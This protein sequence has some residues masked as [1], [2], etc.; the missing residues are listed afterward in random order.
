[1]TFREKYG[2]WAVVAGASEG[3]GAAFAHALAKRGLHVALLARREAELRALATELEAAHKVETKVL[4]T[5][6]ATT[7]FSALRELDAFLGETGRA[8]LLQASA[9]RRAA[10]RSCRAAFPERPD[11]RSR[12]H[13]VG[14]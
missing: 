6:L 11:A 5:D 8:P 3:L 2:P 9:T 10:R 13:A 12:P 7:D 4:V 1:M 14:R